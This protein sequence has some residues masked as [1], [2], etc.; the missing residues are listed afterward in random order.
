MYEI[1]IPDIPTVWNNFLT[2]YRDEIDITNSLSLSNILKKYN[3]F[4]IE[5]N[6]NYYLMFLHEKDKTWFLMKYG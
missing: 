6:R 3:A 1:S 5:G 2:M 4:Y